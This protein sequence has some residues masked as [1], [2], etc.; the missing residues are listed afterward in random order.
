MSVIYPSSII[1]G[2]LTAVLNAL[3]S[4]SSNAVLRIGSAGFGSILSSVQLTK[5]SGTVGS[6][7]LTFTTPRSD[8]LVAASG[9]ATI[10]RLEDS[11]GNIVA[12]G[13]TVGVSTAFDVVVS[14]VLLSSGNSLALISGQIIGN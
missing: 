11:A 1:N 6:G 14:T 13:L 2:R 4:G 12:T 9:I 5:P 8:P 3:D 10:A 7:V